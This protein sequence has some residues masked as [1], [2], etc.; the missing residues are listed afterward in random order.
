MQRGVRRCPVRGTPL[1]LGELASVWVDEP[2][3]PFQIAMVGVFDGT[4]FARSDGSL[5]VSRIRMELAHR[6]PAVPRL[7]RR[8]AWDRPGKGRPHWVE[9]APF[10]PMRHITCASLPR[11]VAF[12]SWC[13]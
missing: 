12:M 13:G 11:G 6:A 10:D 2:V 4:P 8:M 3:A 7:R 5:D 1:T 9:D